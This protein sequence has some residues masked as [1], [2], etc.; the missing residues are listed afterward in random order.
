MKNY[1]LFLFISAIIYVVSCGYVQ[2][3]SKDNATEPAEFQHK[4]FA[5]KKCESCHG[6][7][8]PNAKDLTSAVPDLCYKCHSKYA[9]KF[10]HSPSALGEC[11]LCHNAHESEHKFFLNE[12]EPDLCY[13]CHEQLEEKMTNDQNSTHSPAVDNC[14]ACHNPHV[15][16]V[17][18][19]LLKKAIQPLCTECHIEED[20]SLSVDISSVTYKH[21]PVDTEK[22]CLHCHD[23]HATVFENHLLAEPMD[24]CLRCHNEEVT[25][26]D[27]SPLINIEKLLQSN[28]THHGPIKEKNCSGCHNPH[29]S[30][31]YRILLDEYPEGFYTDTFDANDYKL[32]FTCHESTILQDKETTT[33]TSF[34][35]GKR[36]LHYLHVNKTAKGR[37]CRA[38]HEIHASNN[39]NHI[40]NS[41]PFGK[42]KWPLQLKY[43]PLYTDTTTGEPCDT[44][45]SSCVKSGGSCVACHGRKMYN[46]KKDE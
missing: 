1:K 12:K 21:K 6:S 4:P 29:G 2:S 27:G 39:F 26:Y 7:D 17:S 38:C 23:P 37:T 22:S 11:L 28:K 34:R 25:A 36:N 14:S 3:Q 46:N 44:P 9:G 15:S 42:I 32:C 13:L 41:V 31:F 5:D 18:S 45:G 40:R 8:K 43:E 19:R 35:D 24:L 20:I 33:L 16:D 30:D 10:D